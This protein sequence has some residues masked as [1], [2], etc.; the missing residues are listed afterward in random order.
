MRAR[1]DWSVQSPIKRGENRRR[2]SPL[3][4]MV[5]EENDCKGE[6]V[7]RQ[8][9]KFPRRCKKKGGYWL[10]LT[11]QY[12]HRFLRGK[13]RYVK[14]HQIQIG[15]SVRKIL[16]FALSPH[17]FPLRSSHVLFKVQQLMQ[18]FFTQNVLIGGQNNEQEPTV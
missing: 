10:T 7:E 9:G 12:V 13:Y 1:C 14:Q 8:W 18:L 5:K 15:I 16:F 6:R 4:M 2:F 17:R 3:L 11:T